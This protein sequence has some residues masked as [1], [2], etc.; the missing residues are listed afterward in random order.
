MYVRVLAAAAG[1]IIH[2][3][4][5][6]LLYTPSTAEWSWMVPEAAVVVTAP[7]QKVDGVVVCQT[8]DHPEYTMVSSVTNCT[9]RYGPVEKMGGILF[10]TFPENSAISESSVELPS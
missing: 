3:Q 6:S 9:R 8:A 1:V 2:V 10:S 7:V 4:F 5:E